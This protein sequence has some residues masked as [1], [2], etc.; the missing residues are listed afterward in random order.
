MRRRRKFDFEIDANFWKMT[1]F[2]QFPS[3]IVDIRHDIDFMKLARSDANLFTEFYMLSTTCSY[4]GG[5]V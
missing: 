1:I 3:T 2:R 4:Q 5:V